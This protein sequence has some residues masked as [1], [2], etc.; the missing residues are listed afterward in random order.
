MSAVA[1]YFGTLLAL[2]MLQG[3]IGVS[4]YSGS[5]PAQLQT[6]PRWHPRDVVTVERPGATLDIQVQNTYR[7]W[8]VVGLLIPILPIPGGRE[9]RPP[10]RVWI[11]IACEDGSCWFDPTR[12]TIRVQGGE[13][14][15]PTGYSGPG[16]GGHSRNWWLLGTRRP[17]GSHH[18]CGIPKTPQTEADERH[19]AT[20]RSLRF[21]ECFNCGRAD[22]PRHFGEGSVH[23]GTSSCFVLF[24][25]VSAAPDNS[26]ALSLQGLTRSGRALDLP[27]IEFESRTYTD[28][29]VAG[30]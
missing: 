5:G 25:D 30:P 23:V 27:E 24:F 16:V 8:T 14:K 2:M 1:K 17:R 3:C 18:G 29:E 22:G 9:P 19:P 10:L 12:V 21:A 13:T 11:D 4:R 20:A 7:T 28:V 6:A 15:Q 26:F